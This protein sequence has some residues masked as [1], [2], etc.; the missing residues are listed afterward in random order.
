MMPEMKVVMSLGLHSTMSSGIKKM[1]APSL[2]ATEMAYLQVAT[3][4]GCI[5]SGSLKWVLWRVMCIPG[6]HQA[7][8]VG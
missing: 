1:V 5:V 6:I 4:Q 2:R 3:K 8:L 7:I